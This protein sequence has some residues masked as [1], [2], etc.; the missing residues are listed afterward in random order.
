M[1]D[2]VVIAEKL[3]FG[4]ESLAR[5]KDEHFGSKVLFVPGLIPGEV[6]QVEVVSN[7]KDYDRGRIISILEPS[8]HRIEPVCSYYSACGGCNQLHVAADFQFTC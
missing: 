5:P 7:H 6:A 2:L 1:T 4:G 3:V 8:P